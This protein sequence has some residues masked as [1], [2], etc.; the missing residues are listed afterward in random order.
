MG[1][2]SLHPEV[3]TGTD[4]ECAGFRGQMAKKLKVQNRHPDTVFGTNIMIL[5]I[6]AEGF[7]KS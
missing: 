6:I 2:Q 7:G 1:G 3:V 5:N 4:P